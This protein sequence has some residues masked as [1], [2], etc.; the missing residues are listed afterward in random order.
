MFRRTGGKVMEERVDFQRRVNDILNEIGTETLSYNKNEFWMIQSPYEY[1]EFYAVEHRL[2]NT[3]IALPL[4][5][6]IHD[7]GHRKSSIMKDGIPYRLPYM[8]HPLLVCRMLVDLHIPLTPEEED[9]L[10]AAA[11]C[12]DMIEDIPFENGGHE[13]HTIYH[14]DP[15]VYETV[16][17]VS[18]RKDFTPEEELDHFHQI[19]AHK[20]AC[21]VKLSDRGNN[22]EDLY[23]MSVWKVHEYVGETQKFF[24]PMCEY[25]KA[26][27]PEILQTIEILEDKMVSLT[28][29]AEILVDRYD[30]REKELEAKVI[31]LR[32]ENEHL[33]DTWKKLWNQGK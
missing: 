23:N 31:L 6:G 24:L 8:I 32:Q 27:Y 19:A 33:R 17:K 25:A 13:L 5:R 29:A 16:K 11:L 3:A 20:L 1:I 4:A 15:R 12:H 2:F 30:A 28:E 10:L 9:I 18:K 22:V 21:L 14:L 7:G 26:H